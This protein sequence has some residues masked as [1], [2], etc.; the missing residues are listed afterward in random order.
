MVAHTCKI[1]TW[2]AKAD[3]E[4]GASWTPRESFS[5][6]AILIVRSDLKRKKVILHVGHIYTGYL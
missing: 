5:A 2:E 6:C 4:F 1:S 3:S